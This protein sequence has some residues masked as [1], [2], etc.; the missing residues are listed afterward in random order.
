MN[1]IA[2]Y[3]HTSTE[4][5]LV[6]LSL[7]LLEFGPLVWAPLSEAYGRKWPV[8]GPAFIAAVF[9]LWTAEA[10]NIQTVL[11]TRFFMRFFGSAPV[12]NTG[13]VLADIWA[14]S[15]RGYAIMGYSIAV[16]V[17]P[18]LAPVAGAAI[19][20]SGL[21]WRWTEYVAGILGIAISVVDVLVLDESYEP[22]LLARK[23]ARLRVETGNW[24]LHASFE[25]WTQKVTLRYYLDKFGKRPFQMLMTPICF[26]IALHASFIFAV[27]YATLAAYP[28]I[29]EEGRGWNVLQ[30]S[31]P[32]LAN[33]IGIVLASALVIFNQRFYNRRAAPGKP[34]PPEARLL[35]MMFG[36]WSF[37]AGLFLI[38]W[39]AEPQYPWIASFIGAAAVGFGFFS[40]FQSALN[41]LVDAFPLYGASAIAANTF[42]RSSFS[43][44][45]PLFIRPM[46]HRLGTGWATSVFGFFATL[47]I[48]IPFVLWIWGPGI[49]R[50][51]KYSMTTH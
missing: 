25:E 10:S 16:T 30:G 15:A 33:F 40:I 3:F 42:L 1:D 23:A 13:G 44:A 51:D 11:I 28:V 37:A 24:A 20:Y 21:S 35:S 26:F 43:A 31:F 47:L 17:G 19:I 27:F 22:V 46:Y 5:S 4:V 36:A 34:A 48:P 12:S 41:Y 29:Y 49:R 6:G 38:A 45:F 50:R 18:T 8:V 7:G 9:S 39:T 14:P 2:A 32:F